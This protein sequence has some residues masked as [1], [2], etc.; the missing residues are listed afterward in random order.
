MGKHDGERAKLVRR[1]NQDLIDVLRDV[2]RSVAHHVP[3]DDLICAEME[4]KKAI[5]LYRSDFPYADSV[6]DTRSRGPGIGST[7]TAL[8]STVESLRSALSEV[9]RINEDLVAMRLFCKK[10]G[11]LGKVKRDLKLWADAAAQAY[12]E[13][14]R[15][16]DHPHD[17]ASRYLAASVA[18]VLR[19]VLK[20]RITMTTD[21]KANGTRGG[22]AYCRLLRATL[23]A[24]GASPPEDLL[25]L[26]QDGRAWLR[27][28]DGE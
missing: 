1:R 16:P 20:G 28:F 8:A 18:R 9:N 21:R 14:C 25:P 7:R 5:E 3:D 26:M 19:D 10:V 27:E 22:A 12:L 6:E 11:A 4:L 2:I 24:G 15:L 17:L 13:A 23:E